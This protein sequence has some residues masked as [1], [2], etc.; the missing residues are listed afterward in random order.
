[1]ANR[2]AAQQ[3]TSSPKNVSRFGLMPVEA[4]TSTIFS[5]SQRPPSPILRVIMTLLRRRPLPA[6][7]NDTPPTRFPSSAGGTAEHLTPQ[8]GPA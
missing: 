5:S 1:M 7:R 2:K 3:F 6:R 8:G 4:T